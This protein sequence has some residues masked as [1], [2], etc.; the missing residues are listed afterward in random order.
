MGRPQQ[1]D[2][3]KQDSL[4]QHLRSISRIPLLTAAEEINL[5]RMVQRGHALEALSEAFEMRTDQG[6]IPTEAWA[7][8]AGIT[9]QELKR[10]LKAAKRAKERMINANLRLVVTIAK[11]YGNNL[12][13]LDDLIQEGNIGLI[14]AVDRYDPTRGYK[15]S[16]YAYWWIRESITRGIA[17]HGRTIR[18]PAH[19]IEIL[20]KLRKAQHFLH[21]KLRRNPT[22]Q[23]I[24]EETGYSLTEVREVLQSSQ[25]TISIDSTKGEHDDQQLLDLIASNLDPVDAPTISELMKRDVHKALN[26]LTDK[27]K[28]LLMMRHGIEYPGE[29]SLSAVARKMGITRDSARGIERRASQSIAKSTSHMR[30]Y[31][32][33]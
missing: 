6:P 5:A 2:Q 33:P 24:A 7:L 17:K 28:D 26:Q 31:I 16:T 20:S 10:Q 12:L 4:G 22:L 32:S 25:A 9:I 18:L 1:I 29:L 3:S 27:E 13:E 23:D 30:D 19:I 21:Q 11:R 8:E 15:F 14:K